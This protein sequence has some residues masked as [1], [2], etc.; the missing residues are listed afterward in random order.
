SLDIVASYTHSGSRVRLYLNDGSASFSLSAELMAGSD[1]MRPL[2]VDLESDGDLDLAVPMAD[3]DR[4]AVWTNDGVGV[5]TPSMDIPT[6]DAPQ[7]IQAADVDAD[8]AVDLAVA[9]WDDSEVRLYSNDGTGVFASYEYFSTPDGVLTAL[10][11]DLDGD[12]GPDL[13]VPVNSAAEFRTW[14]NNRDADCNGNGSPDL[15]DIAAGLALDCNGNNTPDSCDIANGFSKD[16]DGNGI[17]DE[18]VPAALASSLEAISIATG[19][20]QDLSL[21]ASADLGLKLYFILGSASGT[22]PGIS[23]NGVHLPL[24]VFDPYFLYSVSE[25]N[26]P[27]FV[28]TLGVLDPLGV[29]TATIDVPVG[30]PGWVGITL[31]HAYLVFGGDQSVLFA[32]NAVPLMLMP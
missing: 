23:L 17:P 4:I 27:P 19:G 21:N 18:C 24:Q 12:A 16:Q 14:I 28:N 22:S 8:G 10:L 3:Q 13:L 5:F 11:D 20:Q 26:A 1:P 7:D 25:P 30:Q 6:A 32:S 9:H 2:P 31:H 29:A 15:Q